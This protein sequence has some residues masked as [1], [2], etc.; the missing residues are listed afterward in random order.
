MPRVRWR[1]L[2]VQAAKFGVCVCVQNRQRGLGRLLPTAQ[3]QGRHGK[4]T[5][6]PPPSPSPLPL[7][8]PP[9][10]WTHTHTHSRMMVGRRADG[11]T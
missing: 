11:S 2:N 1:F 3:T 7:P 10:A 4:G 8:P 6:Q 5:V 9:H